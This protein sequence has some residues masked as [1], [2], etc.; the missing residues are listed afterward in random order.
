MLKIFITSLQAYNNGELKGEWVSLPNDNIEEIC[1][2]IKV[3]EYDELFITDFDTDLNIQINEFDNIEKLNKLAEQI[4]E[5]DEYELLGLN[6]YLENGENVED[7][8]EHA[9]DII[10]Y[11]NCSSM[12]DVAYQYAEESGLIDEIPENLQCYFD[13]K[14]LA[15][16]MEI[17]NTFIDFKTG[18]IELVA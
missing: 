15:R 14:K 3:N 1:N 13:Y 10:V 17:E 12:E 5:L 8:I 4:E 11:D 6:A 18:Y 2:K 7:A 16:D 9:T